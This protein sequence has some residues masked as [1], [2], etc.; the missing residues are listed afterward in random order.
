MTGIVAREGRGDG[1]EPVDPKEIQ[2]G[3]PAAALQRLGTSPQGLTSAE[4]ARRL[5]SFGPNLV[6][7]VRRTSHWVRLL[8]EFT[9]FFALI[10]WASAA[11]ALVS[12][13][14][15]P[16]GGMLVLGI[17][18]IG[19]ILVNGLFSYWQTF[20]GERAL[21]ALQRLLPN[22]VRAMRDGRIMSVGADTLVPGDIVL[23]EQ[24]DAIPADCRMVAGFSAQVNDAALTGESLP[25]PREPSSSTASAPM[26]S[27]NLLLTGTMLIAGEAT[28][29]VYATGPCS[30]IGQIAHLTQAAGETLSPLQHEVVRLSRLIGALAT[31]VG[32]LFFAIGN[33]RGL[34]LSE[35]F[36]FA[37]GV[38]V[39]NVPEGLLPT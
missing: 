19:V 23:L 37:I 33:F 30:Q 18:I 17:A 7:R 5:E 26:E 12:E 29:V 4:A 9:H 6:E 11:L 24:G 35:D 8:R 25:R 39:A 21:E 13:W 2:R 10:L 38:I 16:G 28:G 15:E 27:A 34:S 22:T 3:E 14:R 20:R 32:V 1:M 31:A 36:I